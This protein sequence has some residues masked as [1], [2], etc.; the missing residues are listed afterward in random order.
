MVAYVD[1]VDSVVTSGQCQ[2]LYQ[3]KIYTNYSLEYR[4]SFMQTMNDILIS[5]TP[6]HLPRHMTIGK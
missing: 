5:S 3:Q 1:Y 4:K 2:L 6:F